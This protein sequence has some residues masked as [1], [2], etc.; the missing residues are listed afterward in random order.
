MTYSK[1]VLTL[2]ALI[3]L[4]AFGS[5]FIDQNSFNATAAPP[6]D[7]VADISPPDVAVTPEQ[8][9]I[10]EHD[11]IVGFTSESRPDCECTSPEKASRARPTQTCEQGLCTWTC[12][13]TCNST[14]EACASE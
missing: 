13:P 7:V 3:A 5:F 6:T 2:I 8:K 1:S 10:N 14:A 12:E 11:S 9:W 4:I